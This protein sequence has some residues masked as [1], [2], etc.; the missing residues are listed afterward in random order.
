MKLDVFLVVLWLGALI[1]L[2][3]ALWTIGE[4][5]RIPLVMLGVSA[6]AALTLYLLWQK[7]GARAALKLAVGVAVLGFA[8]EF[9]GSKTGFPFGAYYYTSALQPQLAG[10]PLLI[11]LAWLMMLPSAW[12]VG[13]VL[14]RRFAP[15][16]RFLWAQAGF[17]ALAMTAWDLFL[18]PQMVAWGLWVWHDSSGGFF[19]IPWSNYAGWLLVSGSI[20]LILRPN[21]LPERLLLWMYAVTWILQSIGLAF[22]W[23]Q[24]APAGIG[25]LIMGG[26]ALSALSNRQRTVSSQR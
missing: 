4:L 16:T 25:F 6:Q 9:L 26:F 1:G 10:V 13:S 23:G 20:T 7:L 18:D 2:P 14:A 11:P 15:P 22:F 3:I 8:A 19:G 24:P 17:S 12:A 5:A 21:H